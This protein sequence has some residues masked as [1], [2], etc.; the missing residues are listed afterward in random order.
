MAAEILKFPGG[1][2]LPWVGE[3]LRGK[4]RGWSAVSNAESMRRQEE[5]RTSRDAGPYLARMVFASG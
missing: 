4:R 3:L 2:H 5:P 1:V